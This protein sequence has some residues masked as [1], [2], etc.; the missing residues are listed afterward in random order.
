MEGT[1]ETTEQLCPLLTHKISFLGKYT[2]E[3]VV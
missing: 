2:S 3:W 1:G